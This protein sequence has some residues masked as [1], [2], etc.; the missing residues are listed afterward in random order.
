MLN[1]VIFYRNSEDLLI[2]A[3]FLLVIHIIFNIAKSSSYNQV[4]KL[5]SVG[6]NLYLNGN[7]TK[8]IILFNKA[9]LKD[10]EAQEA[11]LYGG[12]SRYY[13]NEYDKALNSLN[14]VIKLDKNENQAYYWRGLTYFQL[15]RISESITD[16]KKAIELGNNE[17]I[18]F[19][20]KIENSKKIENY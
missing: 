12:I 11:F 2:I 19:L 13:L 15:D 1:V 7:Y 5:L 6:Y 4:Y 8:A 10:P 20:K 18:D 14:N 16:L 3:F 17:A 9:L